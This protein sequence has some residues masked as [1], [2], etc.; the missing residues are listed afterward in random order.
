M[1][2][3]KNP[4]HQLEIYHSLYVLMEEQSEDKFKQEMA[5]FISLWEVKEPKF[6]QYFTKTYALR[7]GKQ[8]KQLMW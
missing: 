2:G 3:V 4:Q 1:A 8:Y 7:A 5:A 6:I